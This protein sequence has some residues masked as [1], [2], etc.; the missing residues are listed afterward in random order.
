MMMFSD[1]ALEIIRNSPEKVGAEVF[2]N[3]I[4]GCTCCWNQIR[5]NVAIVAEETMWSTR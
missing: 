1:Q 2:R 3:V 5:E 4:F